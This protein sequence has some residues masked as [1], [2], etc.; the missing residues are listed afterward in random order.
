MDLTCGE[1]VS[2]IAVVGICL[3][4]LKHQTVS[5]PPSLVR[6]FPL[7]GHLLHVNTDFRVNIPKW[8]MKC[9]DIFSVQLGAQLFVVLNGYDVIKEALVKKTDD[10]SERPRM[11]MDEIMIAQ[12]RDVQINSGPVWKEK[13]TVVITILKKFGMGKKLLASRVQDEVKYYLDHLHGFDGHPVDIRRITTLSTANIIC[14]ILTGQRYAYHDETLCKLVDEM[15]RFTNSNQQ[16]AVT[17]FFPFLKYLR[18]DTALRRGVLEIQRR[19]QSFIESSKDK[20]SEDNFIASYQAEREG[21]LRR[22]EATTMNEFNL[23]K[24]VFDL[25]LGGTE[26]TSTTITW[27]ALFM[28]NYPDVQEKIFEEINKCVG[29]ERPPTLED[30]PKLVYLNAAIK[31]TLR[32]A[33]ILPQSVARLCPNEVILRGYTIPKGTII[34]PNLDSVLFDETIWGPDPWS[35]RPERFIDEKGEIKNPE[36]LIPFGIGH[37]ACPGESLAQ[38]ELFLYLSSLIQRY[39]LLPVMPGVPSSLNYKCGLTMTPEYFQIK[40][41]ERKK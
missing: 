27:F 12:G 15:D 9:G 33:S 4:L 40:L 10:F 11:H 20:D 5:L 2:V 24:T 39:H 6:P 22:G 7:I 17:I 16:A 14:H 36:E 13:R 1:A 41:M 18:R 3:F 31:E 23:L 35:F 28:L 30:R 8:R 38:T 19:L 26:T 29:T 21:K 34:V 32:R 37:R 25:F